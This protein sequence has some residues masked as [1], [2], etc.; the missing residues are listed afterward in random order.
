LSVTR[1]PKPGSAASQ[2]SIR[3]FAGGL[4]FLTVLSVNVIEGICKI[5]GMIRAGAKHG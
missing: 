2:Y 1:R 5:E 4:T 3:P